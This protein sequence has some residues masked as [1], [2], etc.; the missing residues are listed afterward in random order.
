MKQALYSELNKEYELARCEYEQ[1]VSLFREVCW[2]NFETQCQNWQAPWHESWGG[3]HIEMHG[4]R[5]CCDRGRTSGEFPIWYSGAVSAAPTL[6]PAIVLS[7]VKDAEKRMHLTRKQ[8][9]A[10]YDWAPGGREYE[11]LLREGEGVAAYNQLQ[12]SK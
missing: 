11:K 6:P 12:S 5:Y 10:P 2:Y 4:A 9:N 7:E 1:L 3:S 8:R